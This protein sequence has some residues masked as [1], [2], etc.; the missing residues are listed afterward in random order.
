MLAAALLLTGMLAFYAGAAAAAADGSCG[1]GE[2][3]YGGWIYLSG[4]VPGSAFIVGEAVEL[5]GTDTDQDGV[6][7]T[8]ES[9]ELNADAATIRVM[10]LA[11]RFPIDKDGLHDAF[12]EKVGAGSGALG[13]EE[14]YLGWQF[15][16]AV[17]GLT[18]A[19]LAVGLAASHRRTGTASLPHR[20]QWKQLRGLVFDG[21]QFA[22]SGELRSASTAGY[23]GDGS[24]AEPALYRPLPDA[25]APPSPKAGA[26][27]NKASS[28]R[29]KSK[30]GKSGKS[31]RKS[32][33]KGGH[34]ALPLPSPP[35]APQTPLAPPAAR[36]WQPTPRSAL[37]LGARETGVKV[38]L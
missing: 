28:K 26:R 36:E 13:F 25:A 31:S 17:M 34:A 30:G 32:K 23:A 10:M 6:Q 1:V 9:I 37:S 22:R 14:H 33:S 11:S 29:S 38:R 7:T 3:S 16:A 18:A 5:R 12:L 27:Q 15:C 20:E 2:M 19:Y 8:V 35:T 4:K 24:G 21:W